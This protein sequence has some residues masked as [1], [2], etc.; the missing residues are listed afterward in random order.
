MEACN[1]PTTG[2][3]ENHRVTFLS[4]SDGSGFCVPTVLS[5]VDLLDSSE[6]YVL[7][8]QTLSNEMNQPVMLKLYERRKMYICAVFILHLAFK[9]EVKGPG[10]QSS[11]ELV[12]W[13]ITSKQKTHDLFVSIIKAQFAGG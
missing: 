12:C 8:Q 1:E 6:I 9:I 13:K 7:N 2:F 5:F 10:S 11:V 3:V 4:E